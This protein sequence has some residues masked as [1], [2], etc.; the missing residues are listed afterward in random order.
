MP[1]ILSLVLDVDRA[2]RDYLSLVGAL[3]AEQ[4][5]WKPSDAVWSVIDNTEHL[6]RAEQAGINMIWDAAE[7]VRRGTRLWT[8]PH[9]H[10]GKSIEQVVA[11]TWGPAAEAPVPARPQWGGPHGYWMAALGSNAAMLAALTPQLEGLDPES[12]VHPHPLSGPLD[13]RQRLEFL[14]FHIDRHREQVKRLMAT[15]GFPA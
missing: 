3:S 2:R 7:G 12:L 4:A 10:R 15:S 14:R 1:I 9:P 13:A 8:A 6:V 5:R 11:E